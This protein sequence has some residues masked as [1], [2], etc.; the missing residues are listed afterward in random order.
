MA[1]CTKCGT[2]LA[3][4][5]VFCTN[6]GTPVGQ[7]QPASQPQYQAQPQAQYQPQPQVQYQPAPQVIVVQGQAQP[8]PA[9]KPQLISEAAADSLSKTSLTMGILSLVFTGLL[10]LIF[11]AVAKSKA[12]TRVAS[13][14]PLDGKAKAGR[15]LGTFG[16]IFGILAM[17]AGFIWL[18][19]VLVGGGLTL[20]QNMDY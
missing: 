4:D 19:V 7:A 9:A 5:A 13:G 11:G 17:V 10:G 6:C 20:L 18:M 14:Y 3:D 15:I 12:N 8:Q 16:I 1:F 2:K